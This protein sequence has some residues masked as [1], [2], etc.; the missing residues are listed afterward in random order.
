[1]KLKDPKITLI[2]DREG[3]TIQLIDSM[4]STTFVEV[5]LTTEQLCSA[6]GR[7]AYCPCEIGVMGLDKVGKKHEN[8]NFEF[9]I[10]EALMNSARGLDRDNSALYNAA[11]KACPE[12]WEPDNYFSSQNTFFSKDKKQYCRVII[13]RWI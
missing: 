3:A 11:K 13:R 2:I 12:G 8:K 6:M 10:N 5:K 9:E 1:M 7:L 4:S